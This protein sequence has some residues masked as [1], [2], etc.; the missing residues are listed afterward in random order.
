LRSNSITYHVT[1]W[2]VPAGQTTFAL[3]EVI[4]GLITSAL[5]IH[6][7]VVNRRISLRV[8]HFGSKCCGCWEES[9]GKERIEMWMCAGVEMRMGNAADTPSIYVCVINPI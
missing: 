4:L 3:G 5:A 1:V 8:K 6:P 9:G 2:V 7:K